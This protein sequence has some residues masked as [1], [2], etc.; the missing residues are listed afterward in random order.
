MSR[1]Q[2]LL[3]WCGTEFD[4]LLLFDECH[5]AKNHREARYG[6][7]GSEEPEATAGEGGGGRK[8]RK[9]A[10]GSMTGLKVAEVQALLPRAAVVYCRCAAG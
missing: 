1:A 9:P 8:K 3:R 7:A 10:D 2:Q 6:A 5:K 4:G